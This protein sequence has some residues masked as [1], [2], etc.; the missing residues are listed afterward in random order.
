MGTDQY[1]KKLMMDRRH[2]LTQTGSILGTA[3]LSPNLLFA[4]SFGVNKTVERVHVVFKTHLDVG[5]TD[6]AANVVRTYFE[7]FIPNVL[8][9]TE[10]F[11]GEGMK[12]RYQWTT[13]S[14]LVYRYLEEASG[15]NRRRMERAIERGDFT[16][17]G[18]PFTTHTELMDKSLFK[19]ATSYS[20][21]LDERF[22]RKTLAAKMTDVPGH[23]R[24]MI[25]VMAESGIELFHVGV[26]TGSAM[27]GVPPL[28]VWKSPNGTELTVMYQHDYG[29][30]ALLPGEKIAVSINFTSDNH[31]P[32]SPEQI[33][34]IYAGLRKQFPHARVFASNLNAVAEEVRLLR[35][36]LPVITQEIGDSW[37][38]GPG[39]D[40]LLMARF[41][42][43]SRLRREW[44]EKGILEA[45]GETDRAF[46]KHLLLIPEH[47]W[48]LHIGSAGNW[49]VYDISK[50]RSSRD[51]PEF[52]KIEASWAE[53][54]ANIDHA[55]A[56]LPAVIKS[57]A[58]SRMKS[59]KPERT[60]MGKHQR[61]DPANGLFDAR[62]F[63]I[64]FDSQTGAVNFLENKLTKRQ[65]ASDT[66]T[67]G[68]FSYQ[69]FSTPEFHKFM[70]Q[71]VPESL[72]RP[73]WIVHSWDKP[74][75]EKSSA[76]TALY[77]TSLKQL[78]H[79][80]RKDGDFFLAQL[81]IPEAGDSGCPKEI[82]V[83]TFLPINE[84]IIK[85]T[86]KWFD[87]PASRLPEACWFS[88]IPDV[89]PDGQFRM[90]KMGQPVSPLDVVKGGNRNLHGVDTGITYEDR[91][92][93]FQL[94]TLDAFLVA[95]GRRALLD[96][97][98]RQP[99]MAGGLHFCLVNNLTGT[100]F[101]M[102]FEDDMQFRFT[103]RFG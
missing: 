54:R 66:Q 52:R 13:G 8:S 78:W 42:E 15:E 46:G 65:W 98:N 96:F 17:H 22:G 14:W 3:F 36:R 92:S 2:F 34:K 99:D 41:R 86:L 58:E 39:S 45:N 94:E 64:G 56:V 87:K 97:E 26:N 11:A 49:D 59:L 38:H 10:Q 89:E 32:H 82:Y 55:L 91:Q 76:K 16:W 48:G 53:K 67:L 80:K 1:D 40:P 71:Y 69:T 60:I 77:F 50:F 6:M 85:M 102:W 95:P 63:K 23:T 70:N 57:E 47:T 44:V 31:G 74:G 33:A 62:Y 7:E 30:V 103:L 4:S 84:P 21:I 20:A 68:L 24:G 35:D 19:L 37:I 51:L 75:L 12:D 28:F 9:L 27:P 101:T 18:L 73:Q 72:G 25:P 5:F 29:G 79:E 81:E 100:N 83:E 90:D 43:L 88:F 61:V 93:G